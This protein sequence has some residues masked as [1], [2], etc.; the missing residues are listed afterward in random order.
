M[1]NIA[2]E[3]W[4]HGMWTKTF[5][6]SEAKA[7]AN[8]LGWQLNFKLQNLFWVDSLKPLQ[9]GGINEHR[10]DRPKTRYC[11]GIEWWLKKYHRYFSTKELSCDVVMDVTSAITWQHAH[12]ALSG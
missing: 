6:R 4:Q 10:S 1:L 3:W 7:L 2:F 5:A 11:F 9:V 8:D 12:K